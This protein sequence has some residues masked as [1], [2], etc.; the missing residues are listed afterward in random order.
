MKNVDA[1]SWRFCLSIILTVLV[2]W[3]T[4]VAPG[5]AA[6]P[7]LQVITEITPPASFIDAHGKLTGLA[8][9]IVRAVQQEIGDQTEIHVMPW[10]RGYQELLTSP[11]VALF[12]TTRT[13]AREN[14][15]QWVG[16]LFTTR[17]IIYARKGSRLHI[18]CLEDAKSI[19][20][21]GVY[22]NDARAQ[23][24]RDRGFDNLDVADRQELNLVKL[25]GGRVDAILYSD[26]TM[27]EFLAKSDTP[28]ELVEAVF[29]IGSRDL[30]IAFSKDSAPETIRIWQEAVDRLEERGELQGIRDKWLP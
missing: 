28:P 6:G 20:R 1:L 12:S 21:I 23:L 30:Y 11:N 9:E 14:L 25:L 7:E 8:V 29:E 15:F 18:T 19:K 13:M 10:A 27:K 4:F 2:S 5:H 17:W 24:L 3:G 22:R 16:P 26:L